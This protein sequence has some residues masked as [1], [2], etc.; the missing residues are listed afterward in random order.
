MGAKRWAP[1]SSPYP[2]WLKTLSK[3]EYDNHLEERRERK[4]H[5]KLKDEMDAVV[6]Y[7][8]NIW[9]SKIN[10]ALAKAINNAEVTGDIDTV[11][12]IYDRLIDNKINITVDTEQPLPW[13]DEL[14]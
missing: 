13:N 1:G 10:N 11:I 3:E 12:K 6:R 5:K 4:E 2:D 9:I 8:K 14:D 7:N